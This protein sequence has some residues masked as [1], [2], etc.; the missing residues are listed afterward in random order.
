MAGLNI[1]RDAEG[2]ALAFRDGDETA[3]LVWGDALE[4]AGDAEGAF[5]VRALPGL[6]E[7]LRV[8]V[9]TL[10]D[11]PGVRA[12]DVA[13][14]LN[15]YGRCGVEVAGS[16]RVDRPSGVWGESRAVRVLVE[17]WDAFHPALEWLARQLD[18]TMVELAFR[19][20]PASLDRRDEGPFNLRRRHLR[21]LRGCIV[22]DCLLRKPRT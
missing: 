1:P 10:R 5:A 12:Q 9:Q 17:R 15:C 21:P 22:S 16:A 4:E 14:R 7:R 6:L 3:R 13:V 8:T 18:L 11:H 2:L 19:R 20:R